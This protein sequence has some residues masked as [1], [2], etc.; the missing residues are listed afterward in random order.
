MTPEQI[1]VN[2][3]LIPKRRLRSGMTIPAIGM[4]T[5]GNDKF[6]SGQVSE[7]VYGAIKG[8]YRLFDCAAAYGNEYEI[9]KVFKRAFNDGIVK[10]EEL[11]IMS[12]VWNDMH[13]QGDVLVACAK[14]LRDLKLDYL[15]IYMVHWPFPNSHKLGATLA[16]INPDNVPFSLD[17]YLSVWRQME[18]LYD[19]GLVR[20]IGM[21]NMT[22][23]KLEQVLPLCRIQ[24]DVLECEISPSFQ[25]WDLFDYCRAHDIQLIGFSPLGSPA[26][27]ARDTEAADIVTFDMPVIRKIADAHHCHPAIV[28]VKWA[29][30]RGHIPIPFSVYE[31]EYLGN[32]HCVTEDPLTDEEMQEIRDADPNFRLIKGKVFLWPGAKSWRAIWDEE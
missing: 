8:G 26:R 9:G 7:A 1:P 4:G 16:D 15:D 6:S 17:E 13:G 24:P 30:Q 31:N 27:P 23:K 22:V 2:R 18:R 5:F 21:S 14:T 19:L 32:L 3:D 29:V 10:R 11:T 12:K 25:Q 20:S 28:C